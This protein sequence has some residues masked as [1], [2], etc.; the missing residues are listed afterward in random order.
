MIIDSDKKFFWHRFGLKY[1]GNID[2]EIPP[3]L[4]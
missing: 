1:D 4:T 3:N 2:T